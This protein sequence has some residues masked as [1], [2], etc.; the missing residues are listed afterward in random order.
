MFTLYI[1]NKYYDSNN[2]N[3]I[4]YNKAKQL[5]QNHTYKVMRYEGFILSSNFLASINPSGPKDKYFM[6]FH[7]SKLFMD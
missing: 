7:L 3:D 4:W 1:N 5:G 6:C 2:V